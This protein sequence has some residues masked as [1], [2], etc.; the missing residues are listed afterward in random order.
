M[1]AQHLNELNIVTT[2]LS[3]VGIEF[4]DEVRAFILLSS[5]PESWNATVTAVSSSSGSNKLKFDDVRDLILSEEIRWKESGESSTSSVLHTESRGRSSN[6][7]YGGGRSKERRSNSKN[8]HSFQNSKTIECWNCGKV[9]HYK[10]QCKSARKNHE[11]K[12]EAN[13]AST[14]RGEDALICSLE[15]K[16]ES[17]VLDS[18]ASFHATSQKEFFENYV[19]G[20]LGKV[21]LGNEQS[22]EIA[23]KGA[24]KIKL[25]GSVWKLKNVRHIPDLTKNLIS[26]G[27][28]AN[29]G[30]ITVFHGD[31]WKIS[32][33]AMTIARGRK[34]GTLYKTEG[35]CHL[36]A[37]AMNENPNL[38][39][40]RLGHMSEK[41]MRIMHS[42]RKLPSL[43][44][45]EFDMC[46]DCIL[47]KHKRVSFQRSERIPKKERL[48]FVHSDVWGPTTV[49]SIGGKR[50]FVTFIDDHSR[51]V[52]TYFLKNKSEVFEAFKI[53]KAM[54]ENE[55]GLK[56]KKLRSDNG[57]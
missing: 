7:G 11:D 13:V 53:W 41:G 27:Q 5:L 46:E 22:C 3:S 34:S 1:V 28:L 29:D 9:G 25:N 55:T 32:K 48:E 6:K 18:R 23:G 44:S 40:R 30:Y 43:R 20:N 4:D 21:Y 16:E 39:H 47:G 38:W 14:S 51:K 12:A 33:G 57:G 45:I 26:V 15:N 19:P 31:N 56:I 36:I 10:N 54:V 42:K 37:V 8:H 52:W 24:V 2:Q 35:A 50:Y 49:S 17:W